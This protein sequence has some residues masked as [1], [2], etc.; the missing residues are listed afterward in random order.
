MTSCSDPKNYFVDWVG[1]KKSQI[2][3][4][5]FHQIG[6]T[7]SSCWREA[8][9]HSK[10]RDKGYRTTFSQ[11]YCGLYQAR[12]R[13][14]NTVSTLQF[15]IWKSPFSTHKG[16]ISLARSFLGQSKNKWQ[17]WGRLRHDK[18]QAFVES[19]SRPVK[20]YF[21]ALLLKT[22]HITVSFFLTQSSANSTCLF[23]PISN[24]HQCHNF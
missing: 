9:F 13:A 10:A 24:L 18:T 5:W 11:L 14:K 3:P 1:D 21:Q 8:W 7:E 2:N 19:L 12:G 16:R 20:A 4:S 23:L 17:K 6:A 22:I 15:Y